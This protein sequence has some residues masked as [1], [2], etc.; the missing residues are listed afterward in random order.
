MGSGSMWSRWLMGLVFAAS[1]ENLVI[2]GVDLDG[3]TR[4]SNLHHL[5]S[6]SFCFSLSLPLFY[7]QS[8]SRT[9][10]EPPVERALV[11]SHAAQWLGSRHVGY[12]AQGTAQF[13]NGWATMFATV[14]LRLAL[15]SG[16]ETMFRSS[17]AGAVFVRAS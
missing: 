1:D 7:D 13:T 3:V 16:V 6:L 14:Q 8:F 5:F 15:G 2:G 11:C 10:Q 9:C 4:L 12:G 17:T